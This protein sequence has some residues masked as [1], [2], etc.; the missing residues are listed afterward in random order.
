[1]HDTA[2]S[3]VTTTVAAGALGISARSLARWW[4][5]G[6]VIPATVTVGGHPRWNVATLRAQLEDQNP[7]NRGD[8]Q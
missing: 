6:K 3:L 4:A 8:A 2:G 5:A 7:T 1:M